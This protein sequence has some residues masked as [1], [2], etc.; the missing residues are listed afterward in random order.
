MSYFMII[1]IILAGVEITTINY[2]L[3]VAVNTISFHDAAS[4]PA[5][6]PFIFFIER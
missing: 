1:L 5:V 6:N 3:P 2:L 4:T